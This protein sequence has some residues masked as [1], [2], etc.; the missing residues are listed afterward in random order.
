M[1]I[2]I[3][4]HKE[5]IKTYEAD[6]DDVNYGVIEDVSR[7]VDI[8]AMASMTEKESMK[9]IS[10]IARDK[11]ADVKSI[12]KEIFDGVTDEE[13][14]QVKPRQISKALY[15]IV[16]YTIEDLVAGMNDAVD[17]KN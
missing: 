7:I 6:I 8:E 17:E 10:S 3:R 9:L 5:I 2:D 4:D 16:V 1:K 12:L 15:E 14:R 13:L 11:A